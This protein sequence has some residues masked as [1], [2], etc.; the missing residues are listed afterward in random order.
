M[1]SDV[2]ELFITMDHALSFV[3]NVEQLKEKQ[4]WFIELIN[5]CVV[6]IEECGSFILK[7]LDR[8]KAGSQSLSLS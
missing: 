7:Y 3:E 4:Q 1:D 8:S 2:T 5:E 6:T